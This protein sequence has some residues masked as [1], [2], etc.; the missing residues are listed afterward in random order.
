MRVLLFGID[1]LAFRV[2]DP[3]IE[4]GLLPHF[5]RI[6]DDGVQGI[7]KSTT[8]P[9]TP[10]AWMTISTG[11][12][13]AAHG[14]YDFWSYDKDEQGQP[15][16]HIVTHRKGGKAVWNL[17]SDWGKRVIVANIPITYPPEPVNGILISGYM[18]PDTNSNITYPTSFKDELLAAVPAYQI[19][20]DP[21]VSGGQIGDPLAETLKMTRARLAMFELLL[22]KPWDF[23]FLGCSG[24]DRIQHLRWDEI[25]ALHPQAVEYY[26][27]LDRALEMMLAELQED[28]VLMVV[29]DHGF[30]G[31]RRKFYIQEYL[32]Q[33]GLLAMRDESK[34]KRAELTGFARNIIR[35][36][37]LQK[38]ARLIRGM[39]RRGGVM[40]VEKEQHAAMLPDL[41]WEKTR[42]W[43][44]S[45]SGFL[46]GYADIFL[47]PSLSEEEIQA[48]VTALQEIRDPETHEPLVTEIH[49][50]DAYGDGPF[51]P[52][53]RHL[54]VLTNEQTTMATELGRGTLWETSD[55]TS[56][57]HQADG[58]LY[59]YGANVKH[60]VNIADTSVYDVVPTLLSLMGMA[61]P[62]ELRGV[63]MQ[64]AFEQLARPS[65]T[66]QEADGLVM[67]KLKKLA[68]KSS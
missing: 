17:L 30:R 37:N 14:V 13:P 35:T 15:Q 12:P 25:M 49:R 22:K 28:D 27:M 1:G 31:I 45:A 4:Q 29:S 3:M 47:H 48:L 64:E 50:E 8:P 52:A 19:D 54:I 32:Y 51:Q 62:E 67:R 59:L 5:K 55:V 6:R 34:R 42:A 18:A 9:M 11:L 7:L 44:P 65:E 53:E 16:A 23:C 43:V 63:V 36:L 58:V 66:Q 39:L 21:A 56:G 38:L 61:I 26:Q 24:A 41:N 40:A 57:I 2:L 68:S 20:L 33:R 46:A 10:P 60:G